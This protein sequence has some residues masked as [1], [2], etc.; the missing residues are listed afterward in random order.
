[1]SSPSGPASPEAT[2]E[3]VADLTLEYEGKVAATLVSRDGHCVLEIANL[4][5]FKT[6]GPALAGRKSAP[7]GEW[8][9]RFARALPD[10]LEIRFR[11]VSIGNFHPRSAPNWEAK[12]AGLPFGSLVVDKLAL[13]RAS[14][15]RG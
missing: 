9:S 1:M 6:L 8:S 11:G 12:A 4:A 15:K 13:L 3:W 14:L 10:P 2:V 7:G 5:A